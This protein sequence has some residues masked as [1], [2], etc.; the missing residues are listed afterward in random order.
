LDAAFAV[1]LEQHTVGNNL[2]VVLILFLFHATLTRTMRHRQVLKRTF[3]ALVADR[4]IQWMRGKQEFH[5][6]ALTVCRFCRFRENYHAIFDPVSTGSLKF[7]HELNLRLSI[8]QY[9]LT[10]G[11]IA[12]RTTNFH[13]T[14]AAHADWLEFGVMAENGNIDA[15][16][17]RR[18]RNGKTFRRDDLLSIY[19]KSDLFRHVCSAKLV[20]RDL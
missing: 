14:H 18:V 6:T 10:R 9:E 8:L 20:I 1:V 2:V 13:E 7:G 12:H 15:R 3:A 4:A 16:H 17:L 11:T 5:R 19:C